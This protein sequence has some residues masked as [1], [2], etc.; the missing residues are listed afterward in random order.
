M[1][2]TLLLTAFAFALLCGGEAA[3]CTTAIVSAGASRT[4]R[5]LLWKQ[6]DTQS[7]ANHLV[8]LQGERYAF[9]GLADSDD[10]AGESIWCGAND[11][12]FAIMNNV[13]YNLRPDSLE[14]K[15][16][17]GMVMK[18]ALGTCAT[19][20]EFERLL[21]ERPHPNGLET[22]YGVIDAEGG[23]AYFEVWD[24]GYTRYDVADAPEGYL[25]RTNFSLS[26]RPDEGRGYTRY[27][28][29][30]RLMAAQSPRKF[31]SGWL[32]DGLGRSFHNAVSGTDL[33][34]GAIP[35]SG[36]AADVEHIPRYTTTASIVIEGVGPGYAPNSS[37]LWCALGYT[38]ACYAIPV[39][40]A[41]GNAIPRSL[42]PAADGKAPANELAQQLKRR[43][44][45]IERD[46]GQVYLDIGLLR[47]QI[48]P[49][50]RRAEALEFKAGGELDRRMRREGFDPAAVE[51][52]NAA[53][54]RRF[55]AYRKEIEKI[56]RL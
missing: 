53:A 38:P 10:P 49:R 20:D 5:P 23:A 43:L 25:F 13:S 21:R 32:L 39:W 37:V 26:G 33:L 34:R 12:G 48:L 9:T 14:N 2:R 4:G 16:Y 45:P 1:K 7:E 18:Q 8:H 15:P 47:R 51:A 35:A 41:A 28:T 29:A 52:F 19:V 17:E 24:Y 22:N 44:F 30:E 56:L 42:T 40:V 55:A 3:A 6:R 54:D 36:L 31:T 46:G 50:V 11:R 27:A